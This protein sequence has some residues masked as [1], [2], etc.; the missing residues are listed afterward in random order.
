MPRRFLVIALGVVIFV[1]APFGFMRWLG[2]DFPADTTPQGAYLRVTLAVTD[3]KF[4]NAFAYLETEA[5][6]ACHSLF[7]YWQRSATLIRTA[8]PEPERTRLLTSQ[9]MLTDI[10]D[11]PHFFAQEA[12]ARGWAARLRRD[13]SGVARVEV[14]GERA[15]V[16]TVR[17]TRYGLR[18]RENGI[19]GL[20]LFTSELRAEAERAA[21][22]FALIEKAAA[23]YQAEQRNTTSPAARPPELSP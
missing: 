8:Y 5:Q 12:R 14:Q 9:R 7:D 21:R 17:G 22:D 16:E 15:T 10:A 3:D 13:L 1:A 4:E 2:R 20:T 6:W 18:R 11:A 19:W 23:D